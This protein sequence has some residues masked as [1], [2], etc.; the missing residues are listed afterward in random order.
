MSTDV[1]SAAATSIVLLRGRLV[2]K[3]DE[4]NARGA[5]EQGCI[6][7]AAQEA[8]TALLLARGLTLPLLEARLR[9]AQGRAV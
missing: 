9:A 6:E 8:A 2:R 1:S 3:R 7:K 5:G 4:R